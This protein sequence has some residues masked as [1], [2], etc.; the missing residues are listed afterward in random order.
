VIRLGGGMN[1]IEA[2]E[3]AAP[4]FFP[5]P[6]R[7]NPAAE[8]R[9]A[10][11][12]ASVLAGNDPTGLVPVV[13]KNR[14]VKGGLPW[15]ACLNLILRCGCVSPHS[16]PQKKGEAGGRSSISVNL[17][18]HR[19][20]CQTHGRRTVATG[21]PWHVSTAVPWQTRLDGSAV[22]TRHGTAVATTLTFVGARGVFPFLNAT[23]A[24]VPRRPC[25]TGSGDL[26]APASKR[27]GGGAP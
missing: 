9:C 20:D 22:V 24:F 12:G 2:A 23:R 18:P 8:H 6:P 26:P 13:K 17:T 27:T 1:Q 5:R 3:P 25:A 7:P 14:V 19:V 21:F 4:L 10:F 11:A 16:P 15:R